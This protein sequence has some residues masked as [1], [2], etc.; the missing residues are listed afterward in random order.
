[1]APIA[2]LCNIQ[3]LYSHKGPICYMLHHIWCSPEE[4]AHGNR[5]WQK[6]SPFPYLL[7]SSLNCDPIIWGGFCLSHGRGEISGRIGWG[8]NLFPG[9]KR[10]ELFSVFCNSQIF[11][12]ITEFPL[13]LTASFFVEVLWLHC[14]GGLDVKM[15]VCFLLCRGC[16][17][18][19]FCLSKVCL[20]LYFNNFFVCFLQ[21]LWGLGK[22]Y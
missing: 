19:L 18:V 12:G 8:L 1:M 6:C 7:S 22:R 5:K 20:F 4:K 9:V 2:P 13:Y 14:S 17:F 16:S 10:S 21:F 15:K 11:A 3:F